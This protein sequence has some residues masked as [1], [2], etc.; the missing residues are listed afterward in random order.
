MSRIKI[1]LVED[2][3]IIAQDFNFKLED[4]GYEV[5]EIATDYTEAIDAIT[6]L[7]FDLALLDI[8][9]NDSK[10]GIDVAQFI[11]ANK[12]LPFLYL[13][14]NADF[15]TVSRAKETKP[16]G[17]ILKPIKNKDLFVA[18]E[19][20]LASIN[21]APP[22]TERE[23]E[24]H[25]FV[26]HKDALVKVLQ[27]DILWLNA[28]GNYTKINTASQRYMIRGNIKETNSKNAFF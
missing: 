1:L 22:I 2:D 21:D 25:L 26:N 7:E 17:Y 8:N 27:N 13:T 6:N 23:S 15:S 9:L 19:M 5:V 18:I 14:S 3:L 24:K 10:D 20:A 28:E 12:P 16:S 11:N 4:L